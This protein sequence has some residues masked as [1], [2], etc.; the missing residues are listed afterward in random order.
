MKS[1]NFYIM[2]KGKEYQIE[3][4]SSNDEMILEYKGILTDKEYWS[5]RKYLYL[6]GFLDKNITF[7]VI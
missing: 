4:N 6:E 5:L 2:Y 1:Y 7:K 3:Y